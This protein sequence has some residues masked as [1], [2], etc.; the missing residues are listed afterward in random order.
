[1]ASA[2]DASMPPSWLSEYHNQQIGADWGH[3]DGQP[4]AASFMIDGIQKGPDLSGPWSSGQGPI[5]DPTSFRNTFGLGMP[6]I[7]GSQESL[8]RGTN[9]LHNH[10]VGAILNGTLATQVTL[11]LEAR[12]N[13]SSRGL[14][15][16]LRQ[17]SIG[18][19]LTAIRTSPGASP[20][21]ALLAPLMT[22]VAQHSVSAEAAETRLSDSGVMEPIN[23][24]CLQPV[25]CSATL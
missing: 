2:G 15:T 23:R 1:M 13:H 3:R 10:S 24:M 21:G 18:I 22:Q 11:A 20:R 14:M 25:K 8:S 19:S 5:R 17:Y 16:T 7:Q 6:D 9:T 4:T 12:A